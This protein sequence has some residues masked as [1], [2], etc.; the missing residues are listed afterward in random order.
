MRSLQREAETIRNILVGKESAYIAPFF[1]TKPYYGM[2]ARLSKDETRRMMDN[3]ISAG[4]LDYLREFGGNIGY[5]IR[6]SERR[7]GYAKRMLSLLLPHCRELGLEKVMI[8]CEVDNEGS[9][10]TI[11]SNGGVYDSTAHEPDEDS[12]LERYWITL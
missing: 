8:S 10:R 11:L 2:F 9:R 4:E 12:D 6:P 7:K 1:V 3:L 5:S